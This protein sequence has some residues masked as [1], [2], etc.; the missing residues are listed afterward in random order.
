MRTSRILL[1]LVV[2]IFSVSALFVPLP[3]SPEELLGLKQGTPDWMDASWVAGI[4]D[5]DNIEFFFFDKGAGFWTPTHADSSRAVMFEYLVE[6]KRGKSS[7]ELQLTTE[8]KKTR[9]L[10]FRHA[11]GRFKMKS[12]RGTIVWT[13]KIT[14]KKSAFDGASKVFYGHP[15]RRG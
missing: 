4:E 2:L 3:Q 12:P 11:T 14:F 5:P 15:E 6:K 13:Q 9:K 1:S 7:Y 8:D 10:A